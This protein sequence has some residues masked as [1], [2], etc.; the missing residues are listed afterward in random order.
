MAYLIERRAQVLYITA[1][2]ITNKGRRCKIV[3]EPRAEYAVI[4]LQ[5]LKE[6]YPISWEMIFETAKR[7]HAENLRV[8]A[9]AKTPG[10]VKSKKLRG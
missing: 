8:E 10:K 3:V 2:L 6:K 4:S 5:G 1:S 9:E 7:R